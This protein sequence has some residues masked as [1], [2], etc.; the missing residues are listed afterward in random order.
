VATQAQLA[1]A[2]VEVLGRPVAPQ[3]R[4]ATAYVEVLSASAVPAARVAETY[5]EVLALR[6]PDPVGFIGWGVPL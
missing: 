2:Y 5:V 4:L 3:A 1:E 6:P